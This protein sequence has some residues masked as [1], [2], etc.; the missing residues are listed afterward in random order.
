MVSF[1][2]IYT[3]S[4]TRFLSHTKVLASSSSFILEPAEQCLELGV[5]IMPMGLVLSGICQFRCI[6]IPICIL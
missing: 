1:I 3:H 2:Y 5:I 6:C 4:E